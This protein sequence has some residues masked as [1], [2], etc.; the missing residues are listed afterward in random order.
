[1]AVSYLFPHVHSSTRGGLALLSPWQSQK[2][3]VTRL[4]S[5]GGMKICS[6]SAGAEKEHEAPGLGAA[7][8]PYPAPSALVSPVIPALEGSGGRLMEPETSWC[9]FQPRF[10]TGRVPEG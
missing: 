1:M 2:G 5:R 3:P 9:S 8:P 6:L 4:G 7:H 10:P